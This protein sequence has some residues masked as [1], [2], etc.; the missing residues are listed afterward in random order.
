MWDFTNHCNYV[1]L[2]RWLK[3]KKKTTIHYIHWNFPPSSSNSSKWRF[4]LGF[5][6]LDKCNVILVLTVSGWEGRSQLHTFFFAGKNLP[7]VTCDIF[8]PHFRPPALLEVSSIRFRV[9]LS[10]FSF[11]GKGGA[12]WKAATPGDS[13][14]RWP[15]L[16]SP[17]VG[18]V[19]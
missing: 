6:N 14:K 13:N 12:S 4:R 7:R 16:I 2:E 15:D 17:N 8:L 19:T 18:L 5:P 11:T 10:T 3:K 9:V 1:K